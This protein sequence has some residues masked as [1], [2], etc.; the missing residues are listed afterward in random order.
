MLEIHQDQFLMLLLMIAAQLEQ[1]QRRLVV[2]AALKKFGHRGVDIFAVARDVGDAGAG[3]QP[4]VGSRMSL[5]DGLVVAVEQIAEGLVVHHVR[6]IVAQDELFEEPGHVRAMPLGGTGR[7]HR[8]WCLIFGRQRRAQLICQ[9]ADVEESP[10]SRR[11]V[12]GRCRNLLS[13]YAIG[14]AHWNTSGGCSSRDKRSNDHSPTTPSLP[15]PRTLS[16]RWAS[17]RWFAYSCVQ[18]STGV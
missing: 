10:C 11:F 8:L 16:T 13:G 1:P 6:R 4:A 15:G 7:G 14:D 3:D 5:A 2:V 12:G 9:C 17:T 18:S